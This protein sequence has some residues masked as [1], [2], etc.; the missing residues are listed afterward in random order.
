[1][2]EIRQATA[3]DVEDIVTL[4]GTMHAESHFSFALYDADKVRGLVSSMV[5][6]TLSCTL[7]ARD[8][9][10]DLVGIMLGALCESW[11][12][13]A[14]YASDFALYVMPD[15]RG[16]S[17]GARLV[18]SFVEWAQTHGCDFADININTGITSDKTAALFARLGAKR[19]G[20]TCRWGFTCGK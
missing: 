5:I 15:K 4:G 9:S 2:T 17:T 7:V 19:A 1:M 11:F 8:E 13:D 16:G 12:C 20:I 10:G 3:D 6:D 14:F 18:R